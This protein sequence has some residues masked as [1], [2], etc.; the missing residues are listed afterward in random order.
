MPEL[1]DGYTLSN[2]KGWKTFDKSVNFPHGTLLLVSAIENL[3]KI[4]LR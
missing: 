1:N 2:L 4:S 3:N